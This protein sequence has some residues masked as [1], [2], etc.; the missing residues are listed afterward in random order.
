M[1]RKLPVASDHVAVVDLSHIVEGLRVNAVL[2]SS[3][4]FD[5]ANTRIHDEANL[6]AIKGSLRTF[7]QVAPLVVRTSNRVVA[8]GNGRLA[9]ALALGWT[10]I[11]AIFK[12]MDAATAAALSIADNR[13]SELASWDEDALNKMLASLPSTLDADLDRM[14]ADL[15]AE[16]GPIVLPAPGDGGDDF[17]VAA[18]AA[19]PCRVQSGEL[20]LIDTFVVCPHCQHENKLPAEGKPDA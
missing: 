20:W 19:G 9:A 8:I 15:R 10:H 1:A 11:A 14:L 2:C 16:H 13:S 5:P 17:D 6:S 4:Q 18:A 7:G 12:D 3:L